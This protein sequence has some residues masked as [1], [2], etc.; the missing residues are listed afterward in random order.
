MGSGRNFLGQ[1]GG[2]P[3]RPHFLSR[4]GI[5]KRVSVLRFR[6]FQAFGQDFAQPAAYRGCMRT[7][8]TVL[9]ALPLILLLESTAAVA[10]QA[11]HAVDLTIPPADVVQRLTLSDESQI[12]GRVE[13][14]DDD[15]IVFRSIADVV[16]RVPRSSILD[17][18]TTSGRV[19]E[20]TFLPNDPHNNRLMFA[21]T[22][23]SLRRGEGYFGVYYVF[24]FVQVGMTDRFS[25][26][27]GTPLIFGDGAHP[28][29]FTPKMQVL[30]RKHVQAAAGIIHITG[31]EDLEAGIAYGVTTVGSD[32]SAVTIGFGR[33]Y[34]GDGGRGILMIGGEHRQSRRIK[35]ITE[36]WFWR[37]EARGFVSG[38]VRLLGERLSADLSLVVPLVDDA[39]VAFPI[40]SFAW[41]F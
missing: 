17:L 36:N 15:A 28:V 41:H 6:T 8:Q 34:S 10:T 5:E 16:M 26:G 22:A 1:I 24:P 39:A 19:V 38:G 14:I 27:G 7:P 32:D 4:H 12:F 31:I 2:N 21:P 20:G 30:S 33:A 37:G 3:S 23:R 29:W 9:V 40:V 25:I 18:R 35:W 11:R 13:S